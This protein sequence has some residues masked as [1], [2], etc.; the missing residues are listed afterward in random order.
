MITVLSRVTVRKRIVHRKELRGV[1]SSRFFMPPPQWGGLQVFWDCRLTLGFF[2]GGLQVF[3][4][5]NHLQNNHDFETQRIFRKVF[6]AGPLAWSPPCPT[7]EAPGCS[8]RAIVVMNGSGASL[9]AIG[10]VGGSGGGREP[11]RDVIAQLKTGFVFRR[12]QRKA[13]GRIRGHS[14]GAALSGH[15]GGCKTPTRGSVGLV[16]P[17]PVLHT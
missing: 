12:S 14:N 13:M 15:Y 11:L 16:S 1:T 4:V 10:H 5:R 6:F 3:G 9:T 7:P 2:W 8:A 17:C